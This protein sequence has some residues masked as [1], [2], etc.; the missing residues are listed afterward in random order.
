MQSMRHFFGHPTSFKRTPDIQSIPYSVGCPPISC[1]WIR[2][3][4]RSFNR[5]IQ[6]LAAILQSGHPTIGRDIQ[7]HPIPRAVGCPEIVPYRIPAWPPAVVRDSELSPYES[8]E[9]ATAYL[10][11]E[12]A[13][14]LRS[15]ADVSTWLVQNCIDFGGAGRLIQTFVVTDSLD[16]EAVTNQS[17]GSARDLHATEQLRTLCSAPVWMAKPV[18]D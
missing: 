9:I 6:P 1:V 3:M 10:G 12:A 4:S 8:A 16:V 15:P 18:Y 14:T 5:D 13:T 17:T 11:A 7:R 2:W